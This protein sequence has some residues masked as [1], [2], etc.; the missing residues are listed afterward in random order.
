M[1]S[2]GRFYLAIVLSITIMTGGG[3][4]FFTTIGE[5]GKPHVKFGHDVR[6][7]GR[8]KNINLT[9]T[10]RESGLR[11]ILVTIN[12]DNKTHVLTSMGLPRKGVRTIPL[13]LSI[14]P[15]T[16]KLHDGIATLS[17]TAV[18][19]SLFKNGTIINRPVTIDITPPAI[20]LLT[21]TNNIN[22]GG[23]GAIAYRTSEPT[24]KSGV[25]VNNNF[26]SGY[27]AGGAEKSAMVAYFGLPAA[28]TGEAINI[29]IIAVDEGGNE[30]A[31]ALPHRLKNKKFRSDKMLLT[32]NFL[33]QKMPEFQPL[34]P[35]LRGKSPLEIFMYVN[36]TIRLANEA[37][38]LEMCRKSDPRQ[39]WGGTFGRMR[40]AAPMAQ[41]GDKRTYFYQ[42]KPLG[43]SVHYGVDL[44]SLANAPVE[45]SNH[46]VVKFAGS[47]GIY[48]NA[49]LIDH[50]QGIFSIYGH[51]SLINAKPGQ[52]VKKGDIIGN[53]GLTG[54]AGGDHLHFGLI[55]GGRFVNPVEWWDPHW[56]QDNVTK[57][58]G[59][60]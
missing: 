29:R 51:L 26:S 57:K 6:S 38:L 21:A 7:I 58:L 40:D 3:W 55:V 36:G 41:F 30:T 10:D 37:T 52:H 34:S 15:Q 4:W 16:L 60:G 45:A 9:I 14:A 25:M 33:N 17:I 54:L 13:Q 32:D 48:G 43:E 47:L 49:I 1:K 27:P 44:A 18:D 5:R 35:E 39:L 53:T 56:I 50:G 2:L 23:C 46:G 12:Q 31:L 11:S 28:P 24:V 19:Y 42:S 8:Q 22:L 59:K 20:Y